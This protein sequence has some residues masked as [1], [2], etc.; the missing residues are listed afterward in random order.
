VPTVPPPIAPTRLELP[1]LLVLAQHP[2]KI[3]WE[4]FHPGVL[5]HRLY[6]DGV[7]GP[8]AALIWFR[9]GGV[10]PLHRHRGYEHI[11]VLAGSQRDEGGLA[12]TGTLLIHTPGSQHRIVSEEGC[13]VLAIYERPV[14]FL[15]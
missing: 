6:G 5:I 14:E 8:S 7:T 11:L 13:I 3:A 2:E 10:V 9:L 15:E 12:Q 1:D 4:P